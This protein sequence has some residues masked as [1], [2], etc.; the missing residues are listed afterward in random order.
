MASKTAKL[1]SAERVAQLLECYGANEIN[2]PE[3]ERAAAINLIKYSPELQQRRHEAQ[4]LDAAMNALTTNEAL[5]QRADAKTVD[6]LMDKLPPQQPSNIKPMSAETTAK[7]RSFINTWLT[8]G[9]AAAAAVVVV[10]TVILKQQFSPTQ[11]T[12]A[13]T[14]AQRELDSWMW[15]QVTGADVQGVDVQEENNG[16]PLT[17]MALVD[18]EMMPVEE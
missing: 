17:L 2:W 10:T 16:E 7:K 11:S 5:Y 3:D 13:T 12:D 6:A 8:Y 18:L 15:D 4:Q 14:I 9:M 1:I